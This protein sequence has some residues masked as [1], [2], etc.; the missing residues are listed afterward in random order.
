MPRT[1]LANAPAGL[2][3]SPNG[4]TTMMSVKPSERGVASAMRMCVA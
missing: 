3:G 2:F 1:V 4:L